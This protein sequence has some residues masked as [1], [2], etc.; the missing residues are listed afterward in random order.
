MK[1][2]YLF[3][4]LTLI[5]FVGCQ[6]QEKSKT[7]KI[8]KK[9]VK[10]KKQNKEVVF[11][12]EKKFEIDINEKL[13]E[14]GIIKFNKFDVSLEGNIVFLN[15]ENI[16]LY[17]NEGELLKI[18]GR[19]GQGPGELNKQSGIA[20]DKD[21]IVVANNGNQRFSIY[22]Q[23]GKLIK[24]LKVSTFS[25]SFI[26]RNSLLANGNYLFCINYIDPKD[27]SICD[28]LSLIAKDDLHEIKILEVK[29]TP[30]PFVGRKIKARY[31]YLTYITTPSKIYTGLS[32][33]D[34]IINIWDLQGKLLGKIKKDNYKKVEVGEQ[35]KKDFLAQF[36][37]EQGKVLGDK[38]FFTKYMPAFN[39]FVVS[40]KGLIYVQTYEKN[41]QNNM[42][43]Y[44]IFDDNQKFVGYTYLPFYTSRDGVYG[45][46]K[47]N[48][49]Y[50]KEYDSQ[51]DKEKFIA[52]KM[53]RK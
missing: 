47:G 49:L 44:D 33:D 37:G 41:K 50:T 11:S 17:S 18:F 15:K 36:K 8:E 27:K 30:N 53:L 20:F 21:K 52:Y 13:E 10:I 31:Q 7:P 39:S 16:S 24:E 3:I 28:K 22:S 6:K 2:F 40:D 5:M 26:F 29:K 32:S 43:K 12:L 19:K 4:I 25:R 46:I 23:D 38:V 35:Y 34:Y 14:K 51:E 1:R 9:T 45:K 42:Y 48:V